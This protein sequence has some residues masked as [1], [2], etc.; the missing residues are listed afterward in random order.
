MTH[1]Q[2]E[3]HVLQYQHRVFGF[4]YHFLGDREEAED[5][6]QE[7]FIRFWNH[8]GEVDGGQPIG[9]LLR[10]T[11]NAS[12][13]ALRRRNSYRKTISGDSEQ[14]ELARGDAPGPA[15]DAESSDFRAMLDQALDRLSEP[16]K[17]LV[18]LRELQDL[19]YQ[20]IADTLALPLTTVK[21]YLHRARKM[22]RDHLT[23]VMHR[24][25][26]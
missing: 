9:W 18:I 12:V 21:V 10:V 16:Y 26:H 23:E 2:F 22:L 25:T 6:T 11:R 14:V 7:V 3:Q 24:E 1:R 4:A 17:S 8:R 13:D 19:S 20:E 15:K 5:V